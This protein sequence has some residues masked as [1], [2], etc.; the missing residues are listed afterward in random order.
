MLRHDPE[1]NAV[2]LRATCAL[3]N[4]IA[5][6]WRTAPGVDADLA[7]QVAIQLMAK[8]SLGAHARDELGI[9]EMTAARPIQA[10]P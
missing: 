2:I 8:D 7:R 5:R 6:Q 4:V 9:S 1:S 3:G 10:A